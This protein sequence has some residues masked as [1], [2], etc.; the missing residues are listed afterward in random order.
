MSKKTRYAELSNIA[1]SEEEAKMSGFDKLTLPY[2][3]TEV[4]MLEKV[5]RDMHN[6]S[7]AVV[8]TK[9]GLEVWRKDMISDKE[10][11]LKSRA[12]G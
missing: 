1:I 2:K 4:L 9:Y 6:V 7:Y 3:E 11:E 12:Y 5:V 8:S 10:A